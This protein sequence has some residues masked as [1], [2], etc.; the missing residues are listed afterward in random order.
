MLFFY[1]YSKRRD[2][3]L[4]TKI[5]QLVKDTVLI[6]IGLFIMALGSAMSYHANLG[7]GSIGTIVDGTHR[8]LGISRGMADITVSVVL[9]VI[10]LFRNRDLINIG[11][12]IS[13]FFTGFSIDFWK[14]V[15]TFMPQHLVVGP[16]IYFVLGLIF[17]A[18]GTGF[19]VA[20]NTGTSAYDA[21]ILTIYRATK[22]Q[23]RNAKILADVI[24]MIVG[25]FMGGTIGIGTVI[26]TVAG[27][28][29]TQFFIKRSTKLL[30]R[31]A[32]LNN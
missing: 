12:I 27:G 28:Y 30:K 5:K 31:K 16:Y 24:L 17:G 13:L 11:T 32:I 3:K 20:V 18:M 21:Y 23:Y 29:L 26:S 19:Y 6:C 8:L 14:E 15:I 2:C 9:L 7:T 10:V 22:W 4:G 25:I 1:D